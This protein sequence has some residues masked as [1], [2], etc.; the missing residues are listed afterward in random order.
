M[1]ERFNRLASSPVTVLPACDRDCQMLMKSMDWMREL[2]GQLP[3]SALVAQDAGMNKILAKQVLEKARATFV[4]VEHFIYQH[5]PTTG[6]PHVANWAFQH[7]AWHFYYTVG[8]PW[9]WMEADCV[10]LKAGWLRDWNAEYVR[11]GKAI[12]GA[13]VGGRGHC[14]GTAIYPPEFPELSTR[15]M[16][17]SDVAWDWEMRQETIAMTHDT[18]LMCHVWGV[19][20]GKPSPY[21]G[22]AASFNNQGEVDAWVCPEAVL[23]HRSK[24]GTLIDRLRER[25]N[26]KHRNSDRVTSGGRGMARV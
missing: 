26:D 9:F 20:N 24:D 2:D 12:M 25:R 7:T 19:E 21:G 14:N 6:W 15:A 22:N 16:Q 17:S 3:F 13:I 23:F 5:P 1:F 11:C 18:K 4:D 10:P 8:R